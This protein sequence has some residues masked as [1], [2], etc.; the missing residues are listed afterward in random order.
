[1]TTKVRIAGLD[2]EIA[3]DEE[4]ERATFVICGP[5]SYF[6]DDVHTTCAF[7]EVPVVHRPYAPKA[8]PKICM[9]CATSPFLL[10]TKES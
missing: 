1:M 4:C 7:C 2:V 9:R 10:T 6:V 3:S 5:T 8:P